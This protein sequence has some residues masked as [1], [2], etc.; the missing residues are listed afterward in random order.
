MRASTRA[1]RGDGV[2]TGRV[3]GREVRMEARKWA[4]SAKGEYSTYIKTLMYSC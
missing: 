1:G 4:C 2:G 3:E